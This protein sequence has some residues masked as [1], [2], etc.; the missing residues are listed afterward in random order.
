MLIKVFY[1]Q[2][3][4]KNYMDNYYELKDRESFSSLSALANGPSEY[5]KYLEREEDENIPEYFLKGK[6]VDDLRCLPIINDD[7][8]EEYFTEN[9]IIN[10]LDSPTGQD[11]TF[12]NYLIDNF[13]ID[14]IDKSVLLESIAELKIYNNIKKEDTLLAKY[15]GIEDY[16]SFYLTAKSVGNPVISFDLYNLC[17]SIING[18]LQDPQTSQYMSNESSGEVEIIN[19]MPI[20][21]SIKRNPDVDVL[22][23]SKLDKVIINHKNQTI[24][25][26]DFKTTS[27]PTESFKSSYIK[28]RYYY[29]AGLYSPALIYK[30][31]K[32]GWCKDYKLLDFLFIVGN[33]VDKPL[34]YSV[35]E[36][37]IQAAFSRG[38]KIG[39]TEIKPIISL[40]DDLLWYRENGFETEKNYYLNGNYEIKVIE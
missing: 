28:Y 26:I 30:Q 31:I 39:F 36:D 13:T 15:E 3:K 25:P 11:L 38:G 23:K 2:K 40:L 12:A 34:V 4:Q 5:V 6:I 16:V 1:L 18:F 33:G 7:T 37:Q 27:S 8:I 22:M 17:K 10:T 32:E 14:Q 19:E 21:W 35:S 24:Q 20:L 9:Y 29:Q